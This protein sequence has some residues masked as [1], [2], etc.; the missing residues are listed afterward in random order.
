MTMEIKI[1]KRINPCPITRATIE[2]VF[3]SAIPLSTVIG[4]VYNEF[5]HDYPNLRELPTS[6][7]PDFIR[8]KEASLQNSPCYL[9]SKE[10]GDYALWVGEKV[11]S[12]TNQGSYVGWEAL[13]AKFGEMHERIKKISLIKKHERI[14]V[15]YSNEFTFNIME[16]INIAISMQGKYLSD[17]GTGVRLSL[18]DDK[19]ITNLNIAN[20]VQM[21]DKKESAKSSVIDIATW[22]GD[23]T[24]DIMQ[25]LED[26]HT[27]E[28]RAFFE[29]LNQDFIENKLNP[30]Y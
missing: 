12:L 2:L 30:E 17:A 16:Q 9:L 15:L 8:R 19:F 13:R 3:D 4:I 27:K 6:Q 26:C 5:K 21:Q 28:K 29:L 24:N 7:M 25:E 10:E 20:D 14:S 1:P 11:L 22:T 18:K 23:I